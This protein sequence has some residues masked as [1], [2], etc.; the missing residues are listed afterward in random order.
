M[1]RLYV[2]GTAGHIDHGKS[3]L[4]RALTGT[5]PDRLE[6]EKRRGMT[7]DLGFAHL[8]LPSG[9]RVGIVDVPG[10]ER[11]IRT[12]VAGAT[13]IDVVLLV[14]AADEGV[15]PQTREHLD[16][17]RFLPVRRGVVVLTKVDLVSDPAWLQLVAD[18]V[19]ALVRGTFLEGAPV[20][21]VSSRTGQGIADLI[22][23]LDVLLDEVPERPA[24]A[25]ARLPIDRAFVMPGFGTVVTGTLWSGRIVPGDVL[26]L[27]PAG[28]PVR[29]R[30]VQSH[31]VPVPAGVAGSRVAVN[32]SGVE[33][34]QVERGH[35]L[36][37]VGVFRPTTL[38]DARVRLLPAASPLPHMARIRMYVG[39]DEAI[40]RLRLLDRPHL[41]PGQ[42]AVAQI[43]LESPVVVAD[44]DPFVLRRYSPLATL[45]GGEI[46]GA[47]PPRRRRGAASV[48]AIEQAAS[49]G[50]DGKV[51]AAVAASGPAG[52]TPEDLARAL[53]ASRS[54]VEEATA[55]LQAAGS[56]L[57]IRGR[58]FHR[59]AVRS[60]SDRILQ[61]L[62]AF[63]RAH[64][65]RAGMPKD[66]LKTVAFP[67]GD[68]RLYA[69]VLADLATSE[70]V[71]EIGGLVR[72]AE[73]RPA[74]SAEEAAVRGRIEAALLRER[75]AP[76]G[77]D[78]LAREV[79]GGSVFER[80]LQALRD[81]GV[82]VEVAPGMH[83]HRQA[84]EE[85]RAIVADEVSKS[86]SVTVASLRDRLQTSRKYALAVLE[87][88]DTIRVTRRLG[89]ARVLLDR[90]PASGGRP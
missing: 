46:L 21:S 73:F 43:Q 83:F 39:A 90:A 42:E 20:V 89:D 18:D 3:A 77:R 35:V 88:F 53:T 2:A 30:G 69:H 84:L 8:D 32:L 17:L 63:H 87:Y 7:I 27:L 81:E 52:T 5:D 14:V 47:H 58:L 60:T 15:M 36:A 26:E 59:E 66:E 48:A 33:A 13:G 67:S 71:Q 28:L 55:S 68:D 76:P 22:R 54:Q 11:L 85:I 57:M 64:P 10:H 45:G 31:G 37:S 80:M 25:P 82:V 41:E 16:I 86:G 12:M 19:R 61:A 23:T 72:R 51:E 49:A 38:V 79:G 6:E 34:D 1:R 4:V 44:G 74:V 70:Q 29:V 50:L 24:D 40:G 78:E 75:F 9:R 65:W 62:E 56:L